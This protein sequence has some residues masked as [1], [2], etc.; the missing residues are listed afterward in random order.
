M[1]R[2]IGLVM[3]CVLV[4]AYACEPDEQPT[5]LPK[6]VSEG[7]F[8]VNEGNF[9]RGNASLSFLNLSGEQKMSDKLFETA[10][11]VPLGDVANS[12]ELINDELYVVVNNSGKIEILNPKSFKRIATIEGFTSPRH[13]LRI[14]DSRALVSDL[15]A[16]ALYA[17]DLASRSIEKKISVAGWIEDLHTVN[18]EVLTTNASYSHVYVIDPSSLE[19]TDS[20]DVGGKTENMFVDKRQNVWVLRHADTEKQIVAAWVRIDAESHKVSATIETSIAKT[21]YSMESTYDETQNKAYYILDGKIHLLNVEQESLQEGILSL[22]DG[23]PYDL[24]AKD[25]FLWV[26]DSKDYNQKGE[27]LQFNIDD[28]KLVSRFDTGLIPGD[29]L[30]YFHEE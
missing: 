17:V 10:N 28:L 29:L 2:V 5:P 12:L 1:N 26:S 16:K 18:G 9:Q 3:L 21:T 15:Y 20:I 22:S 30:Y 27:L 8:L 13:I 6:E 19:L 11:G 7:I 23:N 14:S 25:D 24:L 4:F